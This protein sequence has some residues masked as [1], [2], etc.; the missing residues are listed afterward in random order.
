MGRKILVCGLLALA[1][2]C[3]G[4]D[5]P[6]A[7]RASEAV[8]PPDTS[9]PV[10]LFLGTSLTAGMGLSSEQAYPA[11]VQMKIDSAGLNYRVVNAG[12]NGET[13]AGGLRRVEWLLRQ[14]VAALVLELGANDMLRGQDVAAMRA[15]L[16]EIIDRTR[17]AHAEAGIVIAGM[18][19][20]PN[21]GEPYASEFART[22]VEL[23]E[24]NDAALIPFLLNGVAGIPELN[25][26]DGN[27]PTAEGQAI[28][29]E[30]VWST[31]APVLL[32][33]EETAR[34]EK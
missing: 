26:P 5:Q 3:G 11:L 27:H 31:L 33:L 28:V 15:N 22:F 18:L 10:V 9:L 4:E 7:E 17:A 8:S 30:N 6:Q 24:E 16:Q 32:E 34:L 20:A 29:A 23:A 2:A 21:L 14:P 13:S 25:Q 19:A 1:A 12:V